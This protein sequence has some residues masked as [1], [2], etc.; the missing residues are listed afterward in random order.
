[1]AGLDFIALG[2]LVLLLLP[3]VLIDLRESRIPNLCN[4][5]LGAVGL[6]QALVRVPELMTLAVALAQAAA[7]FFLLA[8]TA[9][10]MQKIDRNARIGWGDLKFLTAASLWVGL[11]G[12]LIVLI[13]ASLVA[14]LV[15][16]ALAPWRG[17]KWREMRP[18]GPALAAGLLAV[19]VTVFIRGA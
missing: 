13:L 3:I 6:G 10:L 11:Q 16:L 14:L 9:W 5:A 4:L 15:T 18:F 19:T 17:V 8:G 1:M 7:T 12:S 2:L